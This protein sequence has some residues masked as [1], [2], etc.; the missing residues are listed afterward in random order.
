MYVSVIC[1][2]IPNTKKVSGFL[3]SCQPLAYFISS[4]SQTKFTRWF[5]SGVYAIDTDDFREN[6]V[7]LWDLTLYIKSLKGSR[8]ITRTNA[9]NKHVWVEDYE[10]VFLVFI[11][12][13]KFLLYIEIYILQINGFVDCSKC[14]FKL[15]YLILF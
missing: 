9:S 13:H 5:T 15:F 1:E 6:W 11:A 2:N 3:L 8:V 4:M 10:A 12:L 7:L 14:F